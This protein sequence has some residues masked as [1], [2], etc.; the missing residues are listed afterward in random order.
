MMDPKI[1]VEYFQLLIMAIE[2]TCD[3]YSYSQKYNP[4][5]LPF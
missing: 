2:K 3:V 5:G 4:K 1:I